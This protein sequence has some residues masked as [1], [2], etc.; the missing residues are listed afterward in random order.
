MSMDA[1]DINAGMDP[2]TTRI[3]LIDDQPITGQLVERML[4]SA[5][6]LELHLCTDP[7]HALSMARTVHPAVILLDMVMPEISGVELLRMMRKMPQLQM[8]PVVM[9][10]AQEESQGKAE[11]F[12]SGANDYLVK[13]PDP[14]EMV[15]RLRYHSGVFCNRIRSREA[16]RRVRESE[17]HVRAIIHSVH[18]GIITVDDQES[19]TLWNSGA[20]RIF[21][22]GETQMIGKPLSILLDHDSLTH[23]GEVLNLLE[24]NFEPETGDQV[25]R[26]FELMG[27]HRKG[28]TFPLEMSLSLWM[29]QG[30]YVRSIVVRDISERKAQQEAI[31]RQANYD[32]LTE[33]PNR[34]LFMRELD[35]WIAQCSRH[36]QRMALMFMDLDRFKWV[37]DTLG[38][39]AGDAVLQE[40]AKRLLEH[41]RRSDLVARL[42]GDEFTI[43][44]TNI[45]SI[46]DV[47][48]VASKIVD[49]IA[50]PY[51][52]EG[53]QADLSASI[54]ITQ[55]PGD[56]EDKDALLR[57]ADMAMY[58]AKKKGRNGYWFFDPLLN[59]T[60]EEA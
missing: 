7:R 44:M 32:S 20:E 60:P 29:A 22:Y 42:A 34:H 58:V 41:T 23:Y 52:V 30:R 33:L 55:F 57:N 12:A 15:A 6:D 2:D 5:P 18:E 54:G 37:N 45:V 17:A 19:I 56:A 36:R 14:I 3:L 4:V 13:L 53:Q 49:A 40:T 48:L 51:E 50:R 16:E 24:Q 38:H 1:T 21:G 10:S 47:R 27:Q 59:A 39:A 25:S 46:Q 35:Q 28:H 11:A 43:I 31:H 26:T 8:V 9:L